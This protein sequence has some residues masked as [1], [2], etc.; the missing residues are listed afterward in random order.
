LKISI[1]TA[2]YNNESTIEECLASVAQQAGDIEH[3]IID[4]LST[5]KTIE[6]IKNYNHVSFFSS[7]KDAGIY[8]ALNKGLNAATGDIIGFLHSDDVFYS[9][10]IIAQIEQFFLEDD[11][12][13][14]IYGDIEFID[15][16]GKKLRFYSSKKFNKNDFSRGK[17]PAHTSFFARK[18]VYDVFKFKLGYKIAAD[19][20]HLLRVF[21]SECYKIDYKPIITTQMLT[22]G[23][24]TKNI[25]SR[26]TINKEIARSCKENGIRTSMFKIYGKYLHKI[27]EF[28]F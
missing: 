9:N 8:D 12:L 11:S 18:K 14:A 25:Q 17:M 16:Q 15:N 22:G 27:F 23:A 28:K 6:I 10:D 1:I 26:I 20:D 21:Y 3:I 5:D 7:E 13:D 2:C 19:F 24:S 4:G